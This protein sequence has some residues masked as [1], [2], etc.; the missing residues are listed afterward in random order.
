MH[1]AQDSQRCGLAHSGPFAEQR[2]DISPPQQATDFL[3]RLR[4]TFALAGVADDHALCRI[5]HVV[6]GEALVSVPHRGPDPHR[7]LQGD[8]RAPARPEDE[9]P[10]WPRPYL[11]VTGPSVIRLGGVTCNH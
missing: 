7:C 9:Q 8:R 1:L 5:G 3:E 4:V 2:F 6:D 11:V 10:G